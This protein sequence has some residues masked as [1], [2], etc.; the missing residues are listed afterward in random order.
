MNLNDDIKKPIIKAIFYF[1]LCFTSTVALA[2]N[3][4]A[5]ALRVLSAQSTKKLAI[6]FAK[7]KCL[8]RLKRIK[9]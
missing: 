9:A 7:V 1:T 3:D 2:E 4:S 6:T 5:P 8:S